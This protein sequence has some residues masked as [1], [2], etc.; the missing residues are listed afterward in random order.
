MIYH[1][2]QIVYT[3]SMDK[4]IKDFFLFKTISYNIDINGRGYIRF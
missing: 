1:L 3:A 4:K 2:T